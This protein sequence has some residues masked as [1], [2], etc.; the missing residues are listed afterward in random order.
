MSLLE[1]E[2]NIQPLT[3]AEKLQLIADITKMLQKE[4][5]GTPV[6]S[7][8]EFPV[9]TPFDINPEVAVNLQAFSQGD[10]K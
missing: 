7:A 10:S 8:H 6:P 4:E 5:I 9:L 3:R 2:K 1:L